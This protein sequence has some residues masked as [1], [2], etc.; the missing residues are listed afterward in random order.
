MATPAYFGVALSVQVFYLLFKNALKF[1]FKSA[2][3]FDFKSASI[4]IPILLVSVSLSFHARGG[5]Q[6]LCQ[7]MKAKFLGGLSHDINETQDKVTFAAHE[8]ATKFDPQ[9]EHLFSTF[10][11]VTACFTS[12][13]HGS[14]DVA[15]AILHAS[16]DTKKALVSVW[17]LVLGGVAVDI[18]LMTYGH[19]IMKTLGN[20]STSMFPTRGFSAEMAT[21]ITILPCSK[22]KLP[23]S[24]THCI[25]GLATSVG[26]FVR[27]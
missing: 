12:S 26:L 14:N 17:I 19:H 4:G 6:V 10:Q 24:S 2:P 15:D 9:T 13:A 1:D 5:G 25:T 22:L 7:R 23:V 3:K 27:R 16:I 11:V 8:H 18:G 21:S 20:K